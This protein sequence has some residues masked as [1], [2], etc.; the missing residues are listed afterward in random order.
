MIREKL[1]ESGIG[2]S[3]KFRMRGRD[4]SRIEALSDAVF[5]F[6]ITLLVVSLE[7]PQTFDALMEMMRGFAAFA[8][9]FAMLIM[10]WYQQYKF[11]RRYGL[12]DALTFVLN[13][14]L[15]F[16]VLFYVYPLKF[17]WTLL[18]NMVLGVDNRVRLPTG[19]LVA[20]VASNQMGKMMVVF[21]VGYVAVFAVFSLLYMRAYSK[22]AELE[23]NQ[24]E[25]LDT[26]AELEENLLHMG[27]GL[28]SIGL[29][30]Q[31]DRMFAALAGYCYAMIGPV[32]TVHG[33]LAGKKRRKLEATLTASAA[34]AEPATDELETKPTQIADV[35]PRI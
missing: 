21:S 1:I 14:V 27:V 32:M 33:M 22:R 2:M 24:L 7:V 4:V 35:S 23:L 6:A 30:S 18:V 13:A 15:L 29:A 20:P 12:N 34:D 11:F 3:T 9:C 10:V 28:V 31:G 17:V 5:G 25:V 16:V 8:V 26:R 19:E